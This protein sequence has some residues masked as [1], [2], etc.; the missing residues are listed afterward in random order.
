MPDRLYFDD[1]LLQPISDHQPCGEDLRYDSLF[2]QIVDARR[3]DDQLATGAWEKVEGRKV[4]DWKEVADLSLGALKTRTKDL[5]FCCFATEAAIH[6]DGFAGAK[7]CFR[8]T[9]EYLYRFW[10]LGLFPTI[11][12]GDLD[13]RAGALTWM[14]DRMPDLIRQ[15]P[16]TARKDG[17]DNYSYARYVQAVEIGT[18]S[19]IA[20]LSAGE[21]ERVESLRRQKWITLDAFDS[22]LQ[23]TKYPE[24][25]AIY[26]SFTES[27]EQ[28]SALEKVVDDRFTQSAPSFSKAKE[29]FEEIRT[30]LAPV[31]MKYA[32]TKPP[33]TAETPRQNIAPGSLTGWAANSIG[34]SASWQ[35]AETLVLSGGVDQG[36]AQMA[37]LASQETSDRGRF[38]KESD[39]C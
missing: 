36:L 13:Y 26:Q 11:E 28:L 12:D 5:R 29:A 23:A 16:I 18:E 17:G 34:D 24:F 2:K 31:A 7:D 27:V 15:I 33:A 4:A 38:S 30:L 32:Q 25:E 20:Q 6:L 37:A 19:A 21:R 10:D 9:K 1:E 3:S 35:E 14:N 8:L 22:S 39:A